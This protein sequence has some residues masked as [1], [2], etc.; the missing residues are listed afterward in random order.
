M[1]RFI[2]SEM[3]L[4]MSKKPPLNKRRIIIFGITA[5]IIIAVLFSACALYLGDYYRADLARI[6][7]FVGTIDVERTELEDGR[8]AFGSGDADV[9]LIFYPGGKVEAEAYVPLMACLAS[10]GILTV[11]VPMPF[12]L[13][14]LDINAA[15]G[16]RELYPEVNAWYIG[17]H[18]LGG[19]M[20]ASY[21]SDHS[22]AFEGMILLGAYSTADLS[23]ADLRV[24]SVYGSE[25][26]VMNREKYEKYKSNLP[27]DFTETIIDGGNHA[28]FGFYGDQSGDGTATLEHEEQI[29]KTADII[30]DF[31]KE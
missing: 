5:L 26:E 23:A 30:A 17:G 9:G 12:N 3:I 27:A 25:D 31:V 7:A 20:A 1:N 4:I 28:G 10:K 11:L 16:I 13:A 15:D 18:S 24:I 6:D 21:I 8:I 22:D 29:R 2:K 14:V 19:S